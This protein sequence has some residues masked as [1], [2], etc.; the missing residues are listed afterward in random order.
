[1]PGHACLDGFYLR[2]C[3]WRELF[4]QVNNLDLNVG[5]SERTGLDYI[6]NTSSLLIGLACRQNAW[7]RLL[8]KL[9]KGASVAENGGMEDQDESQGLQALREAQK[10]LTDQFRKES[11]PER[12]TELL[13]KLSDNR[14]AIESL[15]GED[16]TQVVPDDDDEDEA[17]NNG[18]DVSLEDLESTSWLTDMDESLNDS[19][20][21]D[22]AEDLPPEMT[23]THGLP[24]TQFETEVASESFTV[25]GVSE[26]SQPDD[27]TPLGDVVEAYTQEEPQIPPPVVENQY[28]PTQ[29]P[30]TEYNN[31]QNSWLAD[32]PT[33]DFGIKET[34]QMTSS[35]SMSNDPGMGEG[36]SKLNGRILVML[37][38][39]LAVAAGAWFLVTQLND[40]DTQADGDPSESSETSEGGVAGIDPASPIDNDRIAQ[41]YQ[42][43]IDRI[44]AATPIHFG[45]NETE[46]TELHKRILNSIADVMVA[47]PG[48]PVKVL[49]FSDPVGTDEA[50]QTLSLARAESVKAYLLT[51]NVPAAGLITEARGESTSSGSAGLA[52]LERRVEFEVQSAVPA[53]ATPGKQLKIGIVAPSARNDLA[54]T[55]GMVDAANVFATERGNVDVEVTDSTFVPAE[56]EAALRG[57]AEQ[58]FDLVLAHGS[59]F[60]AAV[61][62]LAPEFPEVAFAW[63][64]ASDT[65]GLPNVYSYESA[66]EQGGYVM[67]ALSTILSE[68][69]VLGVVGPIEVGDAK[70][71]VDGFKAGALAEESEIDLKVEYTGSFSDTS[72]AAEVAKGHI[73]AKADVMTGTG[74]M[75]VGAVSVASENGTLWFGTQANQASMAPNLVVASQVYHWEV[76]LREIMKDVESGNL[77]SRRYTADLANGGI[78]IEYNQGYALADEVRQR[79]NAIVEAIKN[80][81]LDVSLPA[82]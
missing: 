22:S 50:N 58:D 81:S 23:E 11:D 5:E 10:D 79:G 82:E 25:E 15:G 27:L 24:E 66:A 21:D 76:I 52:N 29:P 2:C 77:E 44:V 34:N 53:T 19:P 13:H 31:T 14:A 51:Q 28:P 59:Q 39:V 17:E 56:A 9:R 7:V 33:A 4:H 43:E 49:G 75:V 61:Q 20:A 26:P 16:E 47:R 37:A 71:Y 67:G 42:S 41:A 48:I 57:Y 60:G 18:A 8:S 35:T 40:D 6:G 68:S 32:E 70:R 12:Q 64:T 63:G 62:K 74:Q 1:M 80:G 30:I 72:L 36:K 45:P 65:F 3:P 54:F 55:Q 46:V 73:G 38:A 78:V 69:K